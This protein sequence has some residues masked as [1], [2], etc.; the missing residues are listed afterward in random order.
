MKLLA[1]EKEVPGVYWADASKEL[2]EREAFEIYKMY[3]S[4]KLREHYFNEENCAVL[5]LECDGKEEAHALL[6]QLPLVTHRLIT[7]DIMEL[8]PYTGYNRV[9]PAPGQLQE[10]HL[11]TTK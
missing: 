3:L 10:S 2:L 11:S 9:I 6:G 7:F 4:E 8:H 5:V 1:V